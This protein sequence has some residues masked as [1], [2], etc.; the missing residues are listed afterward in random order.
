M[1]SL[2]A[3]RIRELREAQRATGPAAILAIG[4]A[5]PVG[6]LLDQ[7]SF[8]DYY[9]NITKSE[10]LQPPKEKL[11]IICD[12]STVK[13][14]YA[15]MTEE[16]LE[17]YPSIRNPNE[18]SL[19][20][21]LGVMI[22]SVPELGK[23]AALRALKEWGRPMSSITHVVF[24]AG[25]GVDMPGADYQLVKR[26][27]LSP[28]VKRVMMYHLGCYGGGTVLRVAKDIVE[29]D[30]DARVLTV[31]VELCTVSSFR[32]TEGIS[33]DTLVAQALFG[34]GA[35]ALVVGADPI[36]GVE[37]PIFEMAFAAQT[38]LP[39]SE[40]KILGQ[41]KENGL[42]VHLDREVPQIVAGNIETSLVH[43]LKQ[44][45]VSD[46]NSIFWVAHP[47]GPAILNQVEAKLQLKPEKL[48][49]TRHVLREFGNM[50]SATVLF[51]LD[52]MRKQSAAEGHATTG[53]GLEWGILCGLGPGIT[54]ETVVLHSVP[55]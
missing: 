10:H 38:I 12:R 7:E 14:R 34:D 44:F 42:R 21:R 22:D 18:A 51:I 13:T 55:I 32:G 29:N 6:N 27:G 23:E 53:E 9:F 25:A 43:A 33:L 8:A 45:G 5:N 16:L 50:S 48:R 49:A 47:G 31:N 1:N 11:K 15:H 28:S 46:W 4:T 3:A 26:L 40:G 19:E 20:A 52:R 17:Q 2:A 54:L 39:E 41:L 36:E 30:R 24:C 35:A 37:N